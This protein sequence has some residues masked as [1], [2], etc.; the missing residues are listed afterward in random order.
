MPEPFEAAHQLC[1]T[2]HDVMAELLRSA[3]LLGRFDYR[4][5]ISTSEVEGFR[6]NPDVFDWIELNGR[7]HERAPLLRARVFPYLLSDLL[8]FLFEALRAARKGKLSVAYALLRKPLQE[9]LYLLELIAVDPE[10]FAVKLSR[11]SLA[12]RLRNVGGPE[13]HCQRIAS[14]IDLLN[15]RDRFDAAYVAQLRYGKHDD[16]FDVPCNLAMHLFTSHESMKTANLNINFIF[17]DFE[18]KTTQWAYIYSRLPYLLSYIRLLVEHVFSNI[19]ADTD[20]VYLEDVERRL[21]AQT[22]LWWNSVE[23]EYRHSKLR[24]FVVVTRLRLRA[25][26]REQGFGSPKLRHLER[27][28]ND[29]AWPDEPDNAVRERHIRYERYAPPRHPFTP[30]E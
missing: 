16:G 3:E 10:A 20:P 9:N 30:D 11:D 26:S 19:N 15:A 28:M 21:Q 14:V 24:R 12:L 29:G 17:S 1:L 8:H 25:K 23:P 7:D 18:A 22:V 2:L 4:I 6:S 5:S 27:M 13:Q